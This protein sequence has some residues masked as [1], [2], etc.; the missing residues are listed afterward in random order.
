M[1]CPFVPISVTGV[2]LCELGLCD[3]FSFCYEKVGLKLHFDLT[4][5]DVNPVDQDFWGSI[6]QLQQANQPILI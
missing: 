4:G 6:C 1:S 2:I 3:S 5:R